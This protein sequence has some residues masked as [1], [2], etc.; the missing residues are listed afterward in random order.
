M[1]KRRASSKDL[2]T[3]TGYDNIQAKPPRKLVP[4]HSSKSASLGSSLQA[5]SVANIS[6]PHKLQHQGSG[7]SS[8]YSSRKTSASPSPQATG[9]TDGSMGLPSAPAGAPPLTS[10]KA[11]PLSG[12]VPAAPVAPVETSASNKNSSSINSMAKEGVPPRSSSSSLKSGN[13]HHHQQQLEPRSLIIGE[14]VLFEGTTEGC[15]AAVIGGKLLGTV[16]SRRLEI[17]RAGK[18]EGMAL[19]ETAEIAGLFEGTLTVT[20][21]LKVLCCLRGRS[22]SLLCVLSCV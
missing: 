10:V 22:R 20:K 13:S 3:K 14:G 6:A 19:A 5:A 2:S 12:F 18:M 9:G 8:S 16:K 17:T 21:S 1:F 4:S 11:I 15:A 7:S